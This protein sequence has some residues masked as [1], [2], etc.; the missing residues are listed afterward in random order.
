MNVSILVPVFPEDE[1]LPP[2]FSALKTFKKAEILFVNHESET[3]L[4]ILRA[5][6]AHRERVRILE[7]KRRGRAESLN[8]AVAQAEGELLLFLSPSS[9]PSASWLKEM[10]EAAEEADLV[11]GE[12]SSALLGK[13]TPYGRLA[14]KLFQGHSKRTAH[15][16]GHA[17]PWGPACNLGIQKSLFETIGPFSPEAAGAFDIDWCWRALLAG[18][19]LRYAPKAAV[20]RFRAN[21][22][23]ALLREFDAYGLGEAWL[24]RS[25]AFLSEAQEEDPLLAGVQAFKRLRFHS[26]AAGV[27]QLQEPLEEVAAAFGSGV[28]TGYER[29][30]RPC[31]MERALPE[32]AIGW[33]SGSKEKTIFVPGKGLTTLQG[34]PLQVWEA[35]A[36]G[37]SE[38]ELLKLFQ[39]L[40]KATPEEASDALEDFISS[41]SPGSS[42]E[43][44]GHHHH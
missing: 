40:F 7:E 41:L 28:R 27:K 17:L 29:P 11:V 42:S 35:W 14:L 13:A 30:H 33:W 26:E 38:E 6:G 2:F 19:S 15:A 22:R 16:Q 39:K 25:Y 32:E 10:E 8:R 4:A 3:N 9:V 37:G 12:T 5:F 23:E 34:K 18:A 1:I 31:A 43:H 36:G 44:E 21:Q 20:K 24:N